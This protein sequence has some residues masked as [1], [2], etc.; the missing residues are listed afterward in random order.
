[1]S[2]LSIWWSMRLAITASLSFRENVR[3]PPV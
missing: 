2:S 3:S 1:M